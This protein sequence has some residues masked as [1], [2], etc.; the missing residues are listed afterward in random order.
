MKKV[1]FFLF[2]LSS[3]TYAQEKIT[4]NG[5]SV[6]F[7]GKFVYSSSSGW[8][9]SYKDYYQVVNDTLY[10]GGYTDNDGNVSYRL[11]FIC[12]RDID[13]N[14][15]AKANGQNVTI[16]SIKTNSGVYGL[17]DL[18]FESKE[19]AD[20]FKTYLG[21][22]M[23]NG[24][25]DE[26]LAQ[27]SGVRD[28]NK[29]KPADATIYFRYSE[30]FIISS[31][32]K[33]LFESETEKQFVEWKGTMLYQIELLKEDG[34]QNVRQTRL[35]VSKIKDFNIFLDELTNELSIETYYRPSVHGVEIKNDVSKD[36]YYDSDFKFK[37]DNVQILEAIIQKFLKHLPTELVDGADAKVCRSYDCFSDY[38]KA[39][40]ERY[41]ALKEAKKQ[42]DAEAKASGN[43][44]DMLANSSKIER[45]GT[46]IY[47][48][49]N[50]YYNSNWQKIGARYF[51]DGYI[52]ENPVY[53]IN[54][55]SVSI[56]GECEYFCEFG[57]LIYS[58]CNSDKILAYKY[59]DGEVRDMSGKLILKV[60]N[61]S[62]VANSFSSEEMIMFIKQMGWEL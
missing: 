36:Y 15:L 28:F 20:E 22:K 12:T 32:Q 29:G 3:L 52:I 30:D 24:A 44:A 18:T 43:K 62:R 55:T 4:A 10:S 9:V 6:S 53:S 21:S 23:N 50:T 37:A 26:I 25:M 45:N 54:N 47:K 61:N 34:I 19:K 46:V 17:G 16:S 13:I 42:A 33:P 48:Y 58:G 11:N 39:W 38:F 27:N 41:Q 31:N 60:S 40:N 35:D 56:N 49:E 8:D 2:F 14:V 51:Q 1:L 7:D 59:K 57:G 5:R